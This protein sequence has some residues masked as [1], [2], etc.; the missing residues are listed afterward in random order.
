MAT[1]A[2][3]D[4]ADGTG[5][6]ATVAGTGG[7]GATVFVAQVTGALG[8]PTWA[9]GGTRTGDGTV[10]LSVA[11][12]LWFAYALV[13]GSITNLVYF[14]A[15]SGLSAVA[16]RVRAAVRDTL[17]LLPYPPFANVYEQ[18]LPDEANVVFPCVILTVDGMQETE[19]IVVNNRDDIGRPVKVMIA[20]RADWRESANLPLYEKWREAAERCFRQQQLPGVIESVKCLIE[21]YV[22][23]DPNARH[24]QHMVTGFVVRAVCR[25]VRGVGQ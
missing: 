1:L 12:G 21:P 17:K 3:V 7:A 24:Y 23:I 2:V 15:S 16:T 19:S 22:I 11:T 25:E 13:G 20:D 4:K 8:S 5:A 6:T 14:Q 10:N 9:T 18:I